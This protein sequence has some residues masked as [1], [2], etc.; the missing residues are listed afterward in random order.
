MLLPAG[1]KAAAPAA[2]KTANRSRQ[3][4]NAGKDEITVYANPQLVNYENLQGME[5]SRCVTAC[6]CVQNYFTA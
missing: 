4:G 6:P 5:K 2:I 3:A 1:N